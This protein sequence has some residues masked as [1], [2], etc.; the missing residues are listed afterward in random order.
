MWP[1]KRQTRTRWPIWSVG[2]IDSLG[3]RNGLTRNAW[4]PRARPSA[5][6]TIVTSSTSELCCFF[7]LLPATGP[8]PVL[9]ALLVVVGVARLIRGRLGGPVRALR[10]GV[11][12]LGR[13]LLGGGLLGE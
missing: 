13:G 1:Q 6:A 4:M 5:T 10:S 9:G 2:T 3:I 12:A 8:G 7:S 11:A